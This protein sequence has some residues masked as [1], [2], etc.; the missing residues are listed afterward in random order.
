MT[1]QLLTL[2][3]GKVVLVLEGGYII[4]PM[5][6]AVEMCMKALLKQEV[7]YQLLDK[8]WSRGSALDCRSLG[9]GFDL[10]LGHLSSCI[11]Y[12]WPSST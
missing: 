2:A 11:I 1:K 4:Q 8:S 3:E 5:C 7:C 6:D 10:C 12:I 9:C